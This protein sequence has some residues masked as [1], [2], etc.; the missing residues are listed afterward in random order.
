MVFLGALSY[1][2]LLEATKKK[3]KCIEKLFKTICISLRRK[4]E[5]LAGGRRTDTGGKGRK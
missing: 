5:E 2:T 4:E 1:R 3:K